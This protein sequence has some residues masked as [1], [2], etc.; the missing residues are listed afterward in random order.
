MASRCGL[1]RPRGLDPNVTLVTVYGNDEN[2]SYGGLQAVLERRFT[3]G[4]G[5]QSNYT[6]RMH[7][8]TPSHQPTATPSGGIDF[9]LVKG[10]STL[11]TRQ[12]FTLAASYKLPFAE[13]A[14]GVT[15]ALAKGWQLNLITFAETSTP[16]TVEN[17]AATVAIPSGADGASEDRP[18]Q[19]GDPFK[20]G[21]V[22]ANP[23]CV[24]PSKVHE[25]GA[26][27]YWFNPCAFE[28]Q[29]PGTWGDEG[30]NTL[31]GPSATDVDF[32]ASKDFSITEKMKLQFTAQ[33]FNLFN[34]VNF[35]FPGADA[36]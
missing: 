15:G 2:N 26:G 7:T 30:R 31:H 24:A 14:T 33:A 35:G 17:N 19:V 16:C 22:A 20:P 23:T 8:T 1:W 13:H 18:N 10:T 27:K 34:H 32:S 6:C 4:L 29:T 3:N 9:V 12:R 36:R 28:Q 25:I 21:P 5:L 11:D